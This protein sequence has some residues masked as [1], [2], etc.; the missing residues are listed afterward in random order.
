MATKQPTTQ[1]NGR[2]KEEGQ[3]VKGLAP[4]AVVTIATGKTQRE[5]LKCFYWWPDTEATG[6]ERHEGN[7]RRGAE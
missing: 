3:E 7:G 5:W 6:S 1:T 4:L 2:L